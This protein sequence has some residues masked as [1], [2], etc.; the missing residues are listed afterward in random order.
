MAGANEE[1]LERSIG[2]ATNAINAVLG[3][4]FQ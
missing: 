3:N 2:A 4:N 1:E